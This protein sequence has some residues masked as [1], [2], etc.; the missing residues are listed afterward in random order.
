VIAYSVVE[1]TREL[2]VRAA[3]GAT[4]ARLIELLVGQGTVL[5]VSGVA[6]GTALA[7]GVSRLLRSL[8]FGVSV[9]DAVT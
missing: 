8:L 3:L 4:P 7:V 1:R 9:T 6:I 5:I 2:G